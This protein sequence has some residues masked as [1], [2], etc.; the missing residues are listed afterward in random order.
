MHMS[1]K[2]L[3]KQLTS[4]YGEKFSPEA[5]NFAISHISVDYNQNALEKAKTYQS[6]MAMSIEKIK[7]QLTSDYGEGFTQAEA[8]FAVTT[9]Q[10]RLQLGNHTLILTI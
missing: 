9:Y 8:D 3:Y 4:Q 1:K 2:G 6:Q 10:N 7:T 5:A